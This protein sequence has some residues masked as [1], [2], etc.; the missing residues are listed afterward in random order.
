VFK[1][2][3]GQVLTG[4]KSVNVPFKEKNARRTDPAQ[5]CGGTHNNLQNF[6]EIEA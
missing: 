5:P 1:V 3:F 4:P 2:K 6:I